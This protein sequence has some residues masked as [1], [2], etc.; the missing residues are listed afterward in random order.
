MQDS[1]FTLGFQR[2]Q[3]LT[4]KQIAALHFK[5]IDLPQD[6]IYK[7]IEQ[8]LTKLSEEEF[9]NIK[10]LTFSNDRDYF[11]N[12]ETA[13]KQVIEVREP[14]KESYE[15]EIQM[16]QDFR[17]YNGGEVDIHNEIDIAMFG[18]ARI[19]QIVY[20]SES[21][22]TNYKSSGMTIHFE[23]LEKIYLAAKKRRKRDMP[24]L[25]YIN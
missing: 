24:L 25:A 20:A 11:R 15:D 13:Y 9:T 21:T 12:S 19:S 7:E 23:E 2:M 16:F 3:L 14:N 6:E 18:N 22:T 4:N 8:Y 5:F 17:A 1:P 10:P